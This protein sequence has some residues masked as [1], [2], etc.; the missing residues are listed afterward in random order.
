VEQVRNRDF[1]ERPELFAYR[2]LMVVQ[3]ANGKDSALT[4]TDPQDYID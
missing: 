4:L 2:P 3:I 1:G